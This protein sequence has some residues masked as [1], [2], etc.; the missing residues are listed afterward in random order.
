MGGDLITCYEEGVLEGLH[1]MH[2][3]CVFGV[4]QNVEWCRYWGEEKMEV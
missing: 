4:Y 3:F 1:V 2:G